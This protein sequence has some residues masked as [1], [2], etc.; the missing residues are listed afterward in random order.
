[1][2]GDEADALKRTSTTPRIGAPDQP[3]VISGVGYRAG[4]Q[5]ALI[6]SY[7]DSLIQKNGGARGLR[8]IG[9]ARNAALVPRFAFIQDPAETSLSSRGGAA[10]RDLRL[11][12]MSSRRETGFVVTKLVISVHLQ[13]AA[14]RGSRTHGNRQNESNVALVI[15]HA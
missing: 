9:R 12:K 5:T 11:K 3:H 6:G 13:G 14:R 15:A 2:V 1:M 7:C 10:S 4:V 8:A